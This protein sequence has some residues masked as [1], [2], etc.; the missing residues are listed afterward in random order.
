M[1]GSL[2][3]W[4]AVTS[5]EGKR[6]ESDRVYLVKAERQLTVWGALGLRK[7]LIELKTIGSS[8]CRTW[9]LLVIYN[10]G[11]REVSDLVS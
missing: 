4:G 10:K 9:S 3:E 2:R 5:A 7:A 11:G 6:G 1:S 8:I